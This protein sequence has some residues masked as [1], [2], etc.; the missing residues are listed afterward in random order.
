VAGKLTWDGVLAWRLG[1]QLLDPVSSAGTVEVVS[2]LCSVQAQ[3]ASAAEL[4]VAVRQARPRTGGVRQAV[5]DRLLIKTWA[6]RGT[7]HVLTAEQAAA[8]LTLL[9]ATR[10]W[11]RGAWQRAF[12]GAAQL[13]A[14]SDA[15]GD[16]LD[17]QVLSREEL[18]ACCATDQAAVSG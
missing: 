8:L 15:V 3:V 1:R 16:A 12:L 7:L 17:G 6:M 18:V 4:A 14:L 2:R 13:R 9:A 10:S 5:E 11:E